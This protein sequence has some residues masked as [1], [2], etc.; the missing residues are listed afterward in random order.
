MLTVTLNFAI[1]CLAFSLLRV[2]KK[3]RRLPTL[4][5]LIII[6]C[7]HCELYHMFARFSTVNLPTIF[8]KQQ[9]ILRG[10]RS[11]LTSS[12]GKVFLTCN[13][14][15]CRSGHRSQPYHASQPGVEPR[16]RMFRNWLYCFH[17]K[18]DVYVCYLHRCLYSSDADPVSIYCNIDCGWSLWAYS[19]IAFSLRRQ[20]WQHKKHE[21]LF[22]FLAWICFAMACI[23]SRRKQFFWRNCLLNLYV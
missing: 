4:F 10:I 17:R 3:S 2:Q 16:I 19:G 5:R 23:L 6:F 21:N 18:C 11:V 13:P 9:Q 12:P 15:F 14:S 8:Q 1:I 7:L 20:L 22:W